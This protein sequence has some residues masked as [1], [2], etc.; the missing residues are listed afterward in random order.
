MK[1]TKDAWRKTTPAEFK[2]LLVEVIGM[3]EDHAEEYLDDRN[4]ISQRVRRALDAA[5]AQGK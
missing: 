3:P 5:I 1:T 2:R 4:A